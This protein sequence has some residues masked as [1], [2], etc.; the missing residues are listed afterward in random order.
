MPHQ[1][2]FVTW[3]WSIDESHLHLSHPSKSCL[4]LWRNSAIVN[5]EGIADGLN[6]SVIIHS[7]V[8]HQGQL[9]RYLDFILPLWAHTKTIVSLRHGWT[10]LLT[11]MGYCSNAKWEHRFRY[12]NNNVG[13]KHVKP[14]LLSCAAHGASSPIR[15]N[16]AGRS[17]WE[18]DLLALC[19]N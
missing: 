1:V 17:S 7:C 9:L 6:Q 12:E 3:F 19:L 13:S 10:N 14:P 15:V 5:W 8:I 16:L 2:N 11:K 4:Y 18:I